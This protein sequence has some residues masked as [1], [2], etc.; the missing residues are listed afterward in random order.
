MFAD[1]DV[2][3]RTLLLQTA[4]AGQ[5]KHSRLRRHSAAGLGP[6]PK[7]LELELGQNGA[8]W[9]FKVN[10]AKESDMDLHNPVT[11]G[12]MDG[13]D[14]MKS[15]AQSGERGGRDSFQ[16]DDDNL[17]ENEL[18]Q[19]QKV[20]NV[21]FSRPVVDSKELDTRLR[22]FRERDMNE[23]ILHPTLKAK[24]DPESRSYLL[25]ITFMIF[26]A[27]FSTSTTGYYQAFYD[28]FSSF[29][30]VY[31][32]EWVIDG[33]FVLNLVVHF[34]TGYVDAEG[35]KVMSLKK[36]RGRYGCSA[37]FFFDLVAALPLD[38]FQLGVGWHPALR[39]NKYLRLYSLK[40]YLRRLLSTSENP[41]V[42]NYIVLLRLVLIWLLLPNIFC[43]F[44]IL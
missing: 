4:L 16:M 9:G 11:I 13:R 6:I 23:E 19:S 28:I 33:L 32:A 39:L 34:N 41:T 22:L 2:R 17:D 8:M 36:I 5:P 20:R 37:D 38:F 15:Q 3:F 25:W 12:G 42:I 24:F 26:C 44:R 31:V 14:S 7:P 40:S 43:V 27:A 10:S 29:H 30:G 35:T 18:E 21:M 1:R